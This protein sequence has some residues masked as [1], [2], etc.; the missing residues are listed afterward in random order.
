V[1]EAELGFL[2]GVDRVKF[3]DKARSCETYKALNVEPLLFRFERFQPRWFGHV[4]RMSQKIL[5][6]QLLLPT[7]AGKR[8]RGR[9][10]GVTT[11]LTLLG[12][13]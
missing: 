6:R 7:P 12:P 3:R 2:Q 8:P 5:A 11:F 1:Q 13:V 4:S 10:G 9:P